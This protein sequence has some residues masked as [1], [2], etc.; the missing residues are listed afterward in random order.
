MHIRR[1]IADDEHD[2]ADVRRRAILTLATTAMSQEQATSWVIG[3]RSNRFAKAIRDHDVWVAVDDIVVG[4]VEVDHDRIVALYVSPAHVTEGI[5]SALLKHAETHIYSIGYTT[6]LLD[7]SPNA[8]RFYLH[9]GYVRNG[10]LDDKGAYPLFK[11]LSK[12]S[13]DDDTRHTD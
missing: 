6:V 9:R 3:V 1:A 13:F 2:I 11:T 5:G 8:L 10:N 7:A 4:W 12:S